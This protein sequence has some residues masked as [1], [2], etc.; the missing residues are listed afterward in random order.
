M[1]PSIKAFLESHKQEAEVKD[2]KV[3]CTLT[4]HELPMSLEAVNNY[5]NGKAIRRAR[6][7]LDNEGLDMT[8]FGPFFKID[9]KRPDTHVFC[10]LTGQ[11][12]NR[13]RTEIL[14]HK[15]GRRYKHFL[16]QHEAKKLKNVSEPPDP[17]SDLDS[18]SPEEKE[19]LEANGDMDLDNDPGEQ[20]EEES[21]WV[22]DA[23]D[24]PSPR[25]PTETHAGKKRKPNQETKNKKKKEKARESASK[26]AFKN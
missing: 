7:K 20:D 1:D 17:C 4:G 22:R 15:N 14:H 26:K 6:S 25:E 3:I 11:A 16:R 13:R 23:R 24:V 2:G 12:L 5:W 18:S 19:T 10:S 8:E 21:F 9:S